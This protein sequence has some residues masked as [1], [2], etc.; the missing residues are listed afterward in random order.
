ME[1]V[2]IDGKNRLKKYEKMANNANCIVYFPTKNIDVVQNC[3]ASTETKAGE[4]T[5][6]AETRR[7]IRARALENGRSSFDF[8]SAGHEQI[9]LMYS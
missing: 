5:Q 2:R 6:R 7:R 8:L 4:L 3:A 1:S 9:G